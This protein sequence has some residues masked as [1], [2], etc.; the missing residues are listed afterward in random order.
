MMRK[1]NRIQCGQIISSQFLIG[2]VVFDHVIDDDK[3]AMG[4]SNRSL[5]LAPSGDQTMV[6]GREISILA[7][8]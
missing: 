2:C 8:G 4:N 7:F 3:E 5:F 6:Q 1:A